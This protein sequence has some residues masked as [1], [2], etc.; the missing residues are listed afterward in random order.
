MIAN[1]F[2]EGVSYIILI[3]LAF[4]WIYYLIQSS[5]AEKRLK[6]RQ[7]LEARADAAKEAADIVEELDLVKSARDLL[8]DLKAALN[9]VMH[10]FTW[11]DL[12]GAIRVDKLQMKLLSEISIQGSRGIELPNLKSSRFG[13]LEQ[14]CVREI[15]SKVFHLQ[16]GD[17]ETDNESR[18]ALRDEMDVNG[19]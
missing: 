19:L 11:T 2:G 3:G 14:D 5:E 13:R 9:I 7:H 4:L 8:P 6:E 16:T 17:T 18:L 10:R 1:I 12:R 15:Q